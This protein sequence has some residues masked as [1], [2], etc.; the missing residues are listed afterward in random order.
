MHIVERLKL[1][2]RIIML[3]AVDT[4]NFQDLDFEQYS[5]KDK[6]DTG[7]PEVQHLVL[8]GGPGGYIGS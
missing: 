3:N 7:K 1:L 6:G 8:F 4:K 2:M 5:V